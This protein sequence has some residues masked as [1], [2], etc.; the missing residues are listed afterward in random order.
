MGK[1]EGPD[2]KSVI[3]EKAVPILSTYLAS[4]L[5][6]GGEPNDHDCVSKHRSAVCTNGRTFITYM[7]V[8]LAIECWF[9]VVS[10]Q[11]KVTDVFPVLFFLFFLFFLAGFV[12]AHGFVY[13][14]SGCIT[15]PSFLAVLIVSSTSFSHRSSGLS[16]RKPGQELKKK[17]KER[18]KKA[19]V[20]SFSPRMTRL[21]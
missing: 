4:R 18:E 16:G 8:L 6:H 3:L 13:G 10:L 20:S 21:S 5:S 2:P 14:G 19:E 12:C 15:L 7:Y 17:I 11:K 1:Q 9:W